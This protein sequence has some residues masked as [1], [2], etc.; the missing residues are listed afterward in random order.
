MAVLG[1][2]IQLYLTDGTPK[3]VIIAHMRNWTGKVLVG[4]S[5]NLGKLLDRYEVSQP[6]IYILQGP[7]SDFPAA[8]RVYIGEAEEV[9]SRLRSHA[10]N[11]DFWESVCVVTVTDE[12]LTKG[13]I[14]YLESRLIELVAAAD[15][16]KL[17]NSTNP[18][19]TRRP[20]PEAD[21]ADMESFLENL[22]LVLPVVGFDLVRPS[23]P[24]SAQ[25]IKAATEPQFDLIHKARGI[26]AR[27]KQIE[28]E[29]IV[30]S[31]SQAVREGG[32]TQNSYA[33]LRERL[34]ADGTVG[35]SNDP[36][37]LVFTKDT[38]FSS[39]SAAGAVVLDRNCNGRRW[40][41]VSG[42]R[43]T[44]HEWQVGAEDGGNSAEV[45]SDDDEEE[46]P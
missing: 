23:S 4:R 21:I 18:S 1:R 42:S 25:P 39:P 44:Y 27:A 12:S 16:V 32:Y 36:E 28:D 34:I 3:G 30:L 24:P 7:D 41:R 20:L 22:T 26:Q 14:Q 15:R 43:T 11:K 5:A 13:H 38:A 6:G 9:S 46:M 2:T 19:S 29:F 45:S 40:W 31:G 8:T 10:K 33:A 17:D 35:Q 37:K